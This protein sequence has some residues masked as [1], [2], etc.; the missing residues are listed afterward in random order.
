[1]T[2]IDVKRGTSLGSRRG[3]PDG[4]AKSVLFC[5]VCGHESPMNGDWHVRQTDGESSVRGETEFVCPECE[6]V[7]LVR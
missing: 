4:R 3:D 2:G 1:M 5:P 6:T 7:V